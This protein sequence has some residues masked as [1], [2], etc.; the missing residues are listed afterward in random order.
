MKQ[1]QSKFPIGWLFSILA[2][3]AYGA[4]IVAAF[5]FDDQVKEGMIFAAAVV[6]VLYLFLALAIRFKKEQILVRFKQ[7]SLRELLCVLL[8]AITTIGSSMLTNHFYV[9]MGKSDEIKA[10]V[11]P[12]IDQMDAM[13]TSYK[14]HTDKRI[15]RYGEYLQSLNERQRTEA[16][17]DGIGVGVIME[18]LRAEISCGAVETKQM[19]WKQDIESNIHHGLGLI[20]LKKQV[21][22]IG[23]ILEET[24]QSLIERDSQSSRGY[25]LGDRNWEYELQASVDVTNKFKKSE[26]ES[27]FSVLAILISILLGFVM[28]LPYLPSERDGRHRGIWWELTHDRASDSLSGQ[29]NDFIGGI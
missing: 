16:G 3:I 13:F 9:V 15:E 6:A 7:S 10:I 27:N 22:D 4:L 8:F 14:N 23:E 1:N 5:Y 20:S 11:Q 25:E 26:S 17:L 21:G 18:D 28:F 19:Q 2:A 24:R 29:I 12:Q